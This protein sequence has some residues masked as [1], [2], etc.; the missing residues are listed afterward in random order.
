MKSLQRD[1][2]TDMRTTNN[3]FSVI[4]CENSESKL[5][6]FGA[7]AEKIKDL[8]SPTYTGRNITVI[9]FQK[10]IRLHT[11]KVLETNFKYGAIFLAI[12]TEL[13]KGSNE[14]RFINSNV[15]SI[16]V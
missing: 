15:N 5:R 4:S 6:M 8:K 7:T 16:V 9:K 12:V 2:R 1:E 10:R 3:R 14:P 13:L 11:L